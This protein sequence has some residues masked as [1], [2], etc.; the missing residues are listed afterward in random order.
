MFQ[1]WR[2]A[3][4]CGHSRVVC[5]YPVECSCSRAVCSI[6]VTLSL[7]ESH[8]MVIV[9]RLSFIVWVRTM[10]LYAHVAETFVLMM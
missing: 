10:I 2:R 4:W 1:S 8:A 3:V 5:F 9:Y 6:L 7:D